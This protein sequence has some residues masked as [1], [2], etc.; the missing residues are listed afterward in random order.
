MKRVAFYPLPD[1]ACLNNPTAYMPT[2]TANPA[3]MGSMP[4]GY[5]TPTARPHTNDPNE[6]VNPAAMAKNVL[7]AFIRIRG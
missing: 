6:T 7:S 4:N 5:E 2:D 3:Y 1:P